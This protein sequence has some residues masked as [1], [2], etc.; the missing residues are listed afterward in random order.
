MAVEER[1]LDNHLIF[2]VAEDRL[3]L[4]NHPAHT[5]YRAGHLVYVVLSY[6]LVPIGIDRAIAVEMHAEVKLRPMLYHRSV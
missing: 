4:Q 6:V 5:V 1:E 2:V 3:S